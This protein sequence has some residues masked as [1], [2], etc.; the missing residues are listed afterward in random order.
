VSV[1]RH[2]EAEEGFEVQPASAN[3]VV[4]TLA[5]VR[6]GVVDAGERLHYQFVPEG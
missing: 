1:F 5:S 3:I 4:R 6:L 2:G